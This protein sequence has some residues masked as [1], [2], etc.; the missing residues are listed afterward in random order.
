M[1]GE[2]VGTY[3]LE[4][5]AT[6]VSTDKYD[7]EEVSIT[8]IFPNIELKKYASVDNQTTWQ[9]ANSPPGPTAVP[10]EDVYFKLVVTNTGNTKLTNIN[11]SDTDF[12]VSSISVVD[13]LTPGTSFEGIIGPYSAINGQHA[14]TATVNAQTPCQKDVSD[15]NP[16]YYYGKEEPSPSVD[17]EKHT[18]GEDA[19]TPTGPYIPVGDSVTWEYAVTNTGNVTLTALSVEDSVLGPIGSLLS[20]SFPLVRQPPLW[21]TEQLPLAS[22]KTLRL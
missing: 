13:P 4:D 21:P 5:T 2:A 7:T 15:S 6:I 14:D 17:I 16:A 10:K 9:D 12:D 18:N 3:T 1:R 11:L 22:M 8:V 19:D 20:L